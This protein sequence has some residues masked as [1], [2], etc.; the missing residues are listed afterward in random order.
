MLGL[1][2]TVSLELSIKDPIKTM[3]ALG[4][5]P[6]ERRGVRQDTGDSARVYGPNRPMIITYQ[7]PL[8]SPSLPLSPSPSLPLFS[9]L[10]LPPSTAR[11]N[12]SSAIFFLSLFYLLSL[13][14]SLFHII[15]FI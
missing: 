15:N 7:T 4:S 8:P 1:T 2:Q 6:G 11:D 12:Y 5:S 3:H 10:S 9:P 14:L 13:S